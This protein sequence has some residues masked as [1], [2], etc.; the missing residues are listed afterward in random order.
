VKKNLLNLAH[1]GKRREKNVDGNSK[2]HH[3]QHAHIYVR[4]NNV[5]TRAR[6]ENIQRRLQ[7]QQQVAAENNAPVA[8]VGKRLLVGNI[9]HK[10]DS[11]CAAIVRGGNCAKS[12]LAGSVPN[13]QLASLVVN[14]DSADLEVNADGGDERRV[15]S[16]VRK[17]EQQAALANTGVAY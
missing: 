8:N 9:V 13:L 14:F 2:Q 15:E 11:H 12:F 5:S 6:R 4:Y 10:E 3:F 16:V 17:A 7:K 1:P